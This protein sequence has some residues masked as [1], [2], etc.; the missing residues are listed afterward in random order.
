MD[1]CGGEWTT[2][3]S[4]FRRSSRRFR[5]ENLV[6]VFV[7]NLPELTV[8]DQLRLAF[9]S[10]GRV[11]DVFIP[12]SSRRGRGFCFGFVRFGNMEIAVRAVN[13]MNGRSFAGRKLGVN[14]AKFGWSQ[15]GRRE[16]LWGYENKRTSGISTD[17]KRVQVHKEGKVPVYSNDPVLGSGQQA[18]GQQARSFLEV[19]KGTH[20]LELQ[21]LCVPKGVVSNNSLWLSNSLVGTVKSEEAISSIISLFEVG[22]FRGVKVSSLGGREVLVSFPDLEESRGILEDPS[23]ECNQIFMSLEKWVPKSSV[24]VRKVWLQCFG[25]PLHG[26]SAEI[27]EAIGRKF[28]EVVEIA[29]GTLDRSVLEVGRICIKT[30]D[31]SFINK[32]LNIKVFNRLFRVVVREELGMQGSLNMN[33]VGYSRVSGEGQIGTRQHLFK[34]KGK[35]VIE[36]ANSTS[37]A[38]NDKLFDR[39][40][41][42]IGMI[43]MR[44]LGEVAGH[45]LCHSVD[46][47]LRDWRTSPQ[48]G[49]GRVQQ[50]AT[51]LHPEGRCCFKIFPLRGTK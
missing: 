9:S 45:D 50:C 47:A 18:T 35:Q 25:V 10:V 5:W 40:D 46:V 8:P 37:D 3:S 33:E 17:F 2:V 28:G 21:F 13:L 43:Q 14:V 16:G 51:A 15:R 34:I 22:G 36:S 4:R 38:R 44:V 42:R 19:V 31:F 1:D 20:Q 48:S 30:E 29:K 6:S 41:G 23:L 49:L 12:A 27:F 24:S 11:F 39:E 32:E 7:N 26:W